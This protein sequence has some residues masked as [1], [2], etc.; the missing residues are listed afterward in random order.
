MNTA[1]P[2]LGAYWSARGEEKDA[3]VTRMLI[4]LER[5]RDELQWSVW[6]PKGAKPKV[7]IELSRQAISGILSTNNR[8]L[9]G[10]P[11]RELGYSAGIWNGNNKL[12]IMISVDCGAYSSRQTNCVVINMPSV[13]AI[14]EESVELYGKALRVVI[15]AWQPDFALATTMQAVAKIA[16]ITA[17]S[18]KGWFVYANGGPLRR[19]QFEE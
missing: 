10:K 19:T 7:A 13:A 6:L 8:D 4:M 12:P 15:D 14:T 2:L 5:F 17:K 9:D 11:I 1:L 16:P 3:C 18:M